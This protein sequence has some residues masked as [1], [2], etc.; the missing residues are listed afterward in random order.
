M[1]NAQTPKSNQPGIPTSRAFIAREVEIFLPESLLRIHRFLHDLKIFF[2][3]RL[4]R[5]EQQGMLEM[6]FRFR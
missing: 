2:R 6:R 1:S 5:I 3:D 4:I